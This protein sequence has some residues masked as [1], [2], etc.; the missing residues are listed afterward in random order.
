MAK[1]RKKPVIIEAHQWLKNGDH[2]EDGDEVFED[3]DFKGELLEGRIVRYYRTPDMDGDKVCN[4]CGRTMHFHGWIDTMEGGHIVCPGDYV[5]TGVVG[6]N[7][8]CKEGVFHA[9]YDEVL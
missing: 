7:Y 1:Y 9:T 8:P 3:G 4:H 2:P 6:E 5:I